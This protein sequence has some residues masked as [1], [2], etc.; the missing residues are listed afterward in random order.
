MACCSVPRLYVLFGIHKTTTTRIIHAILGTLAHATSG[1]IYRLDRYVTP[2]TL[3][4]CSTVNYPKCTLIVDCTEVRTETHSSEAAAYAV[5][6]LQEWIYSYVLGSERPVWSYCIRVQ[7]VRRPLHRHA[8][9]VELWVFGCGWGRRRRP[10]RQR[11][12]RH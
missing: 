12:P 10:C 3:P 7:S 4:D 11:L 1:W 5:L 9:C 8:H 2:Q 6:K